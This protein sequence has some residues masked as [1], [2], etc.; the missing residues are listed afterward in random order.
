MQILIRHSPQFHHE[1]VL[2]SHSRAMTMLKIQPNA[3]HTALFKTPERAAEMEYSQPLLPNLSNGLITLRTRAD[4]F[5][6]YLNLQGQV[7]L[8]ALLSK[9]TY[10]LGIMAGRN[11]GSGADAVLRKYVGQPSIVLVSSSDGLES[12]LL[13]LIHQHEYDGVM[14]YSY[15][16]QYVVRQLKL[17]PHDF[18]FLPI[19]EQ[20]PLQS[21]YVACSKS[22]FGKQ[23]ITAINHTLADPSVRKEMEAAYRYWLDDASATRWDR[24]RASWRAIP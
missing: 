7:Q 5:K 12:R 20:E 9:S 3:C 14:G 6:P 13:K 10:R 15:E 1:R 22:D 21:I 11:F 17:N 2:A 19:A 16:L 24:L 4:Q 18:V 8:E 23:I